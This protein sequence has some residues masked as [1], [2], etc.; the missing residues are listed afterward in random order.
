MNNPP[1]DFSKSLVTPGSNLPA[2]QAWQPSSNMWLDPQQEESGLDFS[3]FVHALRRRW[4]PATLIGATLASIVAGVMYLFVP[5]SYQAMALIRVST[6]QGNVMGDSGM[7]NMIQYD[8]FKQTQ[9]QLITSP[10]VLNDAV[11][12]LE[13]KALPTLVAEPNQ[14]DFLQEEIRVD[15]SKNMGEIIRVT[16]N[17]ANREDTIQIVQAVVDSYISEVAGTEESELMKKLQTL[18]DMERQQQIAYKEKLDKVDKLAKELG[19]SDT[20]VAEINER[21]GLERYQSLIRKADVL[22]SQSEELQTQ[23]YM[24]QSMSQGQDIEPNPYDVDLMLERDQ[25]YYEAKLMMD[26][27]NQQLAQSGSTPRGP[28]ANRFAVERAQLQR[29]M[30]ERRR[31]LIPKIVHVLKRELYDTDDIVNSRTMT[32]LQAELNATAK[33][34]EMA[35]KEAE[36]QLDAI[37]NLSNYSAE[38]DAE[39]SYLDGLKETINDVAREKFKTEMNLK[40]TRR[41]EQVQPAIV[42]D[43]DAFFMKLLQMAGA[44]FL[45]LIGTVAGITGWDYMSHRVNV[46]RDLEKKAGVPV[47]GSLPKVRGRASMAGG[48]KS[49]DITDSIDSIRAAI[50]YGRTGTKSVVITSAVGQEGKSTVASQLA[51]SLA[52]SGLKTLLLDGDV[53]RPSQHA[54]FGLPPDRGLCDVL[55]N[56]VELQSVVQATPAEN[57]WIMPAGRCDQVAFQALAGPV[58]AGLM[59]QLKD[60]FDFVVVDSGPVL[61][62]PEAM[63]FGQ[64]VDGAVISSRRDISQVPKVEEAFSRL[65]SVG[66]PVIGSVVNGIVAETRTRLIPMAT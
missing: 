43:E 53:R 40:A 1:Q 62:G 13:P 32:G 51:V 55:R 3:A 61:T 37:K 30:D 41:I 33:R 50:T 25:Q 11:R 20:D 17:G 45:T 52:R 23:L 59:Q 54:V 57:L 7:T 48:R 10:L 15:Y 66:I 36:Q 21:I 31:E 9:G 38:L 58:L 39:K 24:A 5:T 18:R 22:R 14:L 16:M 63:I 6:S 44:W 47:I 42:P 2:Q 56:Q 8:V 34:Y 28:T 65:R 12:D 46:S 19:T 4:L 60:Q 27:L 49:A 35:M 29:T 64:H 26:Q